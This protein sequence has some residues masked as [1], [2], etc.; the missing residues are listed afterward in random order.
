MICSQ[1]TW[2]PHWNS[3]LHF[4]SEVRQVEPKAFHSH[5][6]TI[7]AGSLCRLFRAFRPPRRQTT[8]ESHPEPDTCHLNQKLWRVGMARW[9][10]TE[11][12]P[13]AS[14]MIRCSVMSALGNS[15]RSS[16]SCMTTTRSDI[17]R[18]SSISLDTKRIAVPSEASRSISI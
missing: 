18:I 1:N 16:P 15:P 4:R 11:T 7:G 5:V 6:K 14:C 2:P 3:R 17:P 8:Y 9:L 10:H 12:C 13:K